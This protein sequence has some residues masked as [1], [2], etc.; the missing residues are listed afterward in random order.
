[1]RTWRVGTVSMGASLLL[2]G[3]FVLLSQVL[4]WKES[5]FFLLAWW[6]VLF[7]ILGAEI[8]IYVWQ[9]RQEAPAVKYDFFSILF[10]G[11]V[12]M[13]GL[14]MSFLSSTGL[15]E[16]AEKVVKAES[17]TDNLPA[18]YDSSLDG[19][20]RVVVD[21]GGYPLRI[22]STREKEI[23]LFGTYQ[24]EGAASAA[25]LETISD[26][27]L[28]EKRGDS[29]FITLKDL[30]YN[31]LETRAHIQQATL[32]IPEELSAEMSGGSSL[33]LNPRG[34]AV[35]WSVEDT[36]ETIIKAGEKENLTIQAEEV[37]ELDKQVW[38]NVRERS[39]E[40][41]SGIQSASK[42]LGKGKGAIKV[43]HAQTVRLD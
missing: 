35:N 17:S 23:A 34:N 1:M 30:P 15:L 41:E 7:I 5:A 12:G 37:E 19:I 22:E 25:K 27:A 42:T 32:L 20:R 16:A 39:G 29:I 9:S 2:L 14:G 40:D 33:A 36:G 11:M 4:Q 31:R 28:I 43:R 8:L 21:A 6:P 13:F 38:E 10:I 18:Y 3:V 26:Y 24:K